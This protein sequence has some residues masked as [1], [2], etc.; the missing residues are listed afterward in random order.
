MKGK[1]LDYSIFER[2]NFERKPVGIKF[3]IKEPE[4]I[5]PLDKPLAI[6]EMFAAAQTRKPFYATAESTQCGEHIVGFVEFPPLMYSGQLGS[7]FSMFRNPAANR[8]VYDYMRVMPKDS[9]K[10][11]THASLDQMDFDPDLLIFTANPAQA[12][13]LLR[14]SSFTNGKKWSIQGSTCLACAWLYSYPYMSG[15]WN[16][17]ISGLGFSMK[18]RNVLPDGWLI[19]SFPWNLI[20]QLIQDL[21]DMEWHPHWYDLGRDG[22]IKAVRQM[23]KDVKQELSIEE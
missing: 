1:R 9:V 8:Q 2:F 7:Q 22:F 18:A 12:E 10:Y 15:E 13:I 19:I 3:S 16:L 11:I 23:E 21:K 6:C 17:Q 4:G 14:A 5:E 20:P